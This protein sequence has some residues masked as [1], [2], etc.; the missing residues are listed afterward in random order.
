MLRRQ[1]CLAETFCQS[2]AILRLAKVDPLAEIWSR[3]LMHPPPPS[4]SLPRG[5]RYSG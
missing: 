5:A 1:S 2:G 3:C 4:R